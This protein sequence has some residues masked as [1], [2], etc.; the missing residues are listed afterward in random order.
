MSVAG[1]VIVCIFVGAA[2]FV[3]G[4]VFGGRYQIKLKPRIRVEEEDEEYDDRKDPRN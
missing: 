3:A 2:C 1:V 4:A